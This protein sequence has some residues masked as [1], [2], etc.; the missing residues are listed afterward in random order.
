MNRIQSIFKDLKTKDIIIPLLISVLPF[1]TYLYKLAPDIHIWETDWFIIN[2]GKWESAKLFLWLIN[3]KS[4]LIVLLIIWFITSN[5]WWR[6]II[7]I[8]TIIELFK[9]GSLFDKSSNSIDEIEFIHSLPFTIPVLIFVFILSKK[10]G[11][12]SNYK[13]LREEINQE[14]ENL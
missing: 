9:L 1:L 13:S 11:C 12:F 5:Y 10:L 8:P 2:S 3:F 7:L 14:I 6:Y 4:L